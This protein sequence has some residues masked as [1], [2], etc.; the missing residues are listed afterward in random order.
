LNETTSGAE[1][2]GAP[3]ARAGSSLAPGD[4]LVLARSGRWRLLVPMRYVERIHGA[5][6]PAVVPSAGSPAH[7]LA[8]IGGSMVPI[9]FCEALLGA[10]SVTLAGSDLMILL[11]DQRRR[12]LLWVSAA[13]EVVPFEPLATD[14]ELPELALAFSG[15]ERAHAVLDVPKLLALAFKPATPTPDAEFRREDDPPR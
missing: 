15:R 9:L 7:A 10:D 1:L 13:E 5:A 4:E 2:D 12:A 3:R 11:R 8:S 6:L 14:A